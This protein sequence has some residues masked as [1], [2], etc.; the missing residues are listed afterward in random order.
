MDVAQFS[1]FRDEFVKL[2]KTRYWLDGESVAEGE[3]KEKYKG[4]PE[5]AKPEGKKK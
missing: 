4:E 2:S 3:F 5:P 1:A